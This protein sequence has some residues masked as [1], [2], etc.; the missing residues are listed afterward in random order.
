MNKTIKTLLLTI[1]LINLA[2]I[3]PA[4]GI[5]HTIS[6]KDIDTTENGEQ[7][8]WTMMYYFNGDN[9]LENMIEQW[10]IHFLKVRSDENVNLIF[11]Y[12]PK[13]SYMEQEGVFRCYVNE[14]NKVNIKELLP[15]QNM[16]DPETLIDFFNWGKTNYP[17]NRYLL[18]LL[19]HGCGWRNGFMLDETNDNDYLSIAELK[20]A[21]TEIKNSLGRKIDI[22]IIESCQM[23][24]T[25]VYYQIKD[26]VEYCISSEALLPDRGYP[27]HMFI[28]EFKDNLQMTNEEAAYT[29]IE[30]SYYYYKGSGIPLTIAAIDIDKFSTDLKN[31][32]DDFAETLRN[33]VKEY[34]K[35][36]KTAL[37]NTQ[38]FNGLQGYEL[39]YNDLYD[40]ALNINEEIQDLEINQAAN[41]L[42]NAIT[43]TV[44]LTKDNGFRANGLSIYI[45]DKKANY[46]N[47]YDELDFSIDSF[48]D[49]YIKTYVNTAKT[50]NLPNILS[51]EIFE[52]IRIIIQKIITNLLQFQ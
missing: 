41:E 17:A 47:E 21:M 6:T 46:Q 40:F 26:T 36:I 7:K 22:A 39:Y 23:G 9:N 15:E 5:E 8:E 32:I 16:A 45:P 14:S 28:D 18:C 4:N 48:W 20:N 3:I 52:N 43:E 11:Q 35:Q 49:E 51:L 27:Y 33:N 12:D 44:I 38:K 34:K 24:Q 10:K 30:R 31:E 50:I 13:E 25:E 29:I 1:I 2:S 37:E 19:G 42:M